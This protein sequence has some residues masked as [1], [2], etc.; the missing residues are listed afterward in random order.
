MTSGIRGFE[1]SCFSD[2][3]GAVLASFRIVKDEAGKSAFTNVWA[4]S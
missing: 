4:E 3:T 1:A 2:R